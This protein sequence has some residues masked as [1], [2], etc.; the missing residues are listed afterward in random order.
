MPVGWLRPK[1]YT[2][3]NLISFDEAVGELAESC[4][5]I[6]AIV[7]ALKMAEMAGYVG[8][9]N[10]GRAFRIETV[11]WQHA[12]VP[13]K[14]YRYTPSSVARLD[15]RRTPDVQP[16]L[17]GNSDLV[18]R[19]FE[20]RNR[21]TV[22]W[23]AYDT[24]L[25]PLDEQMDQQYLYLDRTEL[26][27]RKDLRAYPAIDAKSADFASRVV[28]L[29]RDL[30]PNASAQR[31]ILDAVRELFPDGGLPESGNKFYEIVAE[32]LGKKAPSDRKTYYTALR[33]L[34]P[35]SESG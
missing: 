22:K 9:P 19:R 33:K 6:A 34:N 13:D 28:G 12:E 8:D 26:E 1:V 24:S 7:T 3:D 4:Q 35:P 23:P 18:W 25:T 21:K 27:T 11:Y 10:T 16:S 5:A 29:I 32:K 31:R 2:I 15:E 30:P 20:S 17:I 14:P